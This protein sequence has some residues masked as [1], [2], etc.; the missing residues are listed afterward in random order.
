MT[1]HKRLRGG[2]VP[3]LRPKYWLLLR[4][5][6]NIKYRRLRAAPWAYTSS[7]WVLGNRKAYKRRGLYPRRLITRIKT[8]SKQ[9]VAMLIKIRSA[10]TRYY[11][12]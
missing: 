1:R 7:L 8:P 4:N 12:N 6:R 5:G 10:S 3:G 9:A 11:Y 2:L